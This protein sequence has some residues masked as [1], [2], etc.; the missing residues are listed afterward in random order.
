METPNPPSPLKTAEDPD[1]VVITGT[2]FSKP[3]SAVLSKHVS[4]SAQPSI[5]YEL[6]KAKLSQYENL[7]FRELCSGFATRRSEERRVG[8]ECRL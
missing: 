1:D 6:S 4:S 5:E 3:A 2:R 8:K 7:E